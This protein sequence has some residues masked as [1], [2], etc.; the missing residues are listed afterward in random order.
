[1]S[2]YKVT[3]KGNATRFKDFS[4]LV[5]AMDEREAVETIYGRFLNDDYFPDRDG[6]I[7]DCDGNIV[8][9]PKSNTIE[10]DGGYFIAELQ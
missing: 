6:N 8:A 5:Q 4:E 3:Y 10:Y 2:M 9:T 1:M 7:F